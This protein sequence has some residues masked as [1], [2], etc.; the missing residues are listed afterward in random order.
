MR[1]LKLG[2]GTTSFVVLSSRSESR[3]SVKSAYHV[4]VTT[5]DMDG[6]NFD[7]RSSSSG[8]SPVWKKLWKLRVPARILHFM[9]RLLTDTLPVPHNLARRR[10]H[11]DSH[12]PLCNSSDTT[13][14]HLFFQCPIA[15]QTWKLAG[16]DGPILHFQ[17]PTASLWARDFIQDSPSNMSEFFTVICNGIWYIRNKKIFDDHLPTPFAIVSSAGSLLS[18][19]HATNGWPE[20]PSSAL[21]ESA[22]LKKALP[23]THIYFDGAISHLNKCAG[24]GLFIRKNDGS[25]LHGFSKSYPSILDPKIY[26]SSAILRA[27]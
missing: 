2:N 8:P 7:P 1:A 3:L 10:I 20:R 16:L 24:I 26:L 18:S 14:V 9:W 11:V 13:T 17:Q 15:M 5:I 4:A 21:S 27:S 19:Y 22:L 12:C 6:G 23:R 25:F